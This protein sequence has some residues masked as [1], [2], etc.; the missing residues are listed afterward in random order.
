MTEPDSEKKLQGE[1]EG[2]E[3]KLLFAAELV[4]RT[5]TRAWILVTWKFRV[6]VRLDAPLLAAPQSFR[7]LCWCHFPGRG[8]DCDSQNFHSQA[9]SGLAPRA[10]KITRTALVLGL[11]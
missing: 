4:K 1:A 8:Q 5:G 3:K 6:A 10:F 9:L 11:L 2:R 7:S